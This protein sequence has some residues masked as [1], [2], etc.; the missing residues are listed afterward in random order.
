MSDLPFDREKARLAALAQYQILDTEPEAAFDHL[1]E[2]GA[3]VCGT[4]IACINF[5][6][7]KRQWLKAK[8]GWDFAQLPH[9]IGVCPVCIQQNGVFIV[10]DLLADPRWSKNAIVTSPFEV[11]FYAGVPLFGFEGQAI[12]TFCVMDRQPRQLSAQQIAALQILGKQVMQLLEM[13][14]V[15][16]R[17]QRLW[18]ALKAC[19]TG[20]WDWDVL[21]NQISWSENSQGLFGVTSELSSSTREAFLA[22]IYPEDRKRVADALDCCLKQK[23]DLEVEFRIVW[24]DR[25]IRWLV[26]QGKVFDKSSARRPVRITGIVQDISDRKQAQLALR[27]SEERLQLV[28]DAIDDA[29]WDWDIV[30]DKCFCSQRFYQF[31]GLPPQEEQ[32]VFYEF[33]LQLIHPQDQKRFAKLLSQHLDFNQPC[34]MELRLGRGDG[35]YNWFLLRGKA[36]RD[37]WG[38]PIRMLGSLSDIGERKQAEEEL[39]QQNQRSQLLAEI[40]LKIRQSL[41]TEEILQTTV[42]EIQKLLGADRVL[43]FQLWNDGS[44]TVVQEAVVP[45]CSSIL[46]QKL[47][48]PC[49]HQD[50]QQAYREGR[51]HVISDLAKANIHPCHKEFLEKLS[52]KAHIVV[53]IILRD[54]LWG[55]LIAQQCLYPRNWSYFEI[56]LLQQ[57]ANQIGIALSQAQLLEQEM[58][59]REELARSNIELEQFAYVASHDLQEPLRMVIS[60]L[61]LLE[62]KYKSQLDRKADEFIA[63]A[64]DGASRM[65]IL[66]NDLLRFSRVSTRAQPFETVDCN[67]VL[68]RA[69]ANLK[70]AIAESGAVI[71]KSES[72]PQVIGDATQLTQLFQNLISNAIKFRSRELAL[73]IEIGVRWVETRGQKTPEGTSHISDLT[74][75]SCSVFYPEWLFWVRDNGIG[76]E[77]QYRDRIFVIF[78][79]LHARGKYAGTGIGLA[80]CKKIVERHGGRIWVES[81]LGQGATFYFTIPDKIGTPS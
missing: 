78:Q 31:L 44:G 50:Y 3:I 11:R 74:S 70:I 79:R 68:Q 47:F 14:R 16:H 19:N 42:T 8:I 30:S 20:I 65:Q 4:P 46:A 69:I 41:R 64:V 43:I 23:T 12:A 77:P 71:T 37:A 48:E 28:I 39:R 49:F 54:A 61:Q 18:L 17:E 53:P 36:I 51:I 67:T 27:Q 38:R 35:A 32:T 63:Y 76:I 1:V 56:D 81:Q 72:L 52:V 75:S 33:F 62:K 34:Q 26:L 57:L 29:I 40:T 2:L 24:R 21:T 5:L 55:L 22:L 13:R 80:I 10:P 25:S 7:E 9:E 6:D 59:Q 73:H 60:Y 45:G 66:I 15:L 58:R